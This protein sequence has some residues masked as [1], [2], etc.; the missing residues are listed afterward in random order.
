MVQ[1]PPSPSGK[2]CG[3]PRAAPVTKKHME[4]LLHLIRSAVPSRDTGS[5]PWQCQCHSTYM[6][7]ACVQQLP[8]EA[9]DSQVTEGAHIISLALGQLLP[10]RVGLSSLATG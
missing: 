7:K 4:E 3:V 6:E 5:T 8:E 10:C 1:A 2:C 9:D